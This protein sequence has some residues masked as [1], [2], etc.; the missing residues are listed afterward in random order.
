MI[1]GIFKQYKQQV[2]DSKLFLFVDHQFI[3]SG[4]SMILRYEYHN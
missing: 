2:H 3:V 4:A 1:G